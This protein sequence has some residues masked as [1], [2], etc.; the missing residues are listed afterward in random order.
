MKIIQ[1]VK[2]IYSWLIDRDK[3]FNR[4]D[5]IIFIKEDSEESISGEIFLCS[6]YGR[7]NLSDLAGEYESNFENVHLSK[8]YHSLTIQGTHGCNREEFSIKIRTE[9]FNGNKFKYLD[10]N[11]E[12]AMLVLQTEEEYLSSVNERPCVVDQLS[13]EEL[14]EYLKTRELPSRIAKN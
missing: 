4:K 10:S 11:D 9:K 1:V 3:Y 5:Y 8:D 12:W 13:S 14:E 2:H 7:L 6:K